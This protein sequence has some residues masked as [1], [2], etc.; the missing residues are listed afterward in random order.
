MNKICLILFA[1]VLFFSCGSNNSES[2][3]RFADY[4][5]SDYDDS[6]WDDTDSI[7]EEDADEEYADSV[8]SDDYGGLEGDQLVY[9]CTGP[10]AD[11]FHVDKD[12]EGLWNCSDE[13]IVVDVATAVDVMWRHPCSYCISD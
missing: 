5:E 8:E 2:V 4:G 9:V 6:S 11:A 7:D 13:I 3:D 12:C 1:L 10:Y